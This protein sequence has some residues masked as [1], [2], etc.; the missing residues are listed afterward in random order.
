MISEGED[1][2]YKTA[3]AGTGTSMPRAGPKPRAGQKRPGEP[4][5]RVAI[6]N[7]YQVIV[8]GLRAMLAPPQYGV[9]VL[10]LD[11]RQSPHTDVDVGLFDSYG[12]PGLGLHRVRSL[13]ADERVG[14]VAVYTWSLTRAAREAAWGAGARGLIA[15]TLPADQ[16]VTSLR[17]VDRHRPLPCST[18]A[19]PPA[20][21]PSSPPPSAAAG[22]LSRP[23]D[24]APPGAVGPSR[25][26]RSARRRPPGSADLATP[27]PPCRGSRSGGH[28]RKETKVSGTWRAVEGTRVAGGHSPQP[29]RATAE[30]YVVSVPE[31]AKLLG[32]SKDLGYDLA[33]RGELPGAFQ[34]GRRWRVSLIKLRSAV[35]GAE[36]GAAQPVGELPIPG[37]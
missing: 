18:S 16:L 19:S 5:L 11:V 6:V 13:V 3:L 9:D 17:A 24:P 28:E 34:L 31:A 12:Q 37:L 27:A 33:R 2:G 21:H 29:R 8:A 7:D 20:A 22:S 15:K 35:H 10:E 23:G 4:P 30:P 25:P 32:I 26:P 1:R 14:S 36:D